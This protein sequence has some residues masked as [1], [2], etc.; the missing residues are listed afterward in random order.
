MET[1]TT[2]V[3]NMFR[4]LPDSANVRKAKKELMAMMEDKY[5]SLIAQNVSENEAIGRVISEFGNIDDIAEQLEI[6]E[7]ISKREII[8]ITME[9]VKKFFK[10]SREYYTNMAFAVAMF[11]ISPVPIFIMIYLQG[12]MPGHMLNLTE[13]NS[14]V[15]GTILCICIVALGVFKLVYNSHKLDD[16][17]KY[18]YTDIDMDETV[19]NYLNKESLYIREKNTGI[20]AL[21]VVMYVISVIPIILATLMEKRTGDIIYYEALVLTFIMIALA[22]YNILKSDYGSKVFDTLLKSDKSSDVPPSAKKKLKYYSSIY[23]SAV[24]ILYLAYSFITA[25]WGLS[26]II[27]VIAGIGSNMLE[28]LYLAKMHK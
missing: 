23:W 13:E 10:K 28:N 14:T 22:T 4:G 21:S 3:N 15:I 6:K 17:E 7:E 25:Q 2:Y 20:I 18:E 1:I 12:K 9:D 11:I 27:W 5:D 8:K 16:F 26:W 24:L 19:K